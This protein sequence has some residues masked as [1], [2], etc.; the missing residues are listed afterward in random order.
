MSDDK[1][2]VAAAS[3]VH[4]SPLLHWHCWE[5]SVVCHSLTASRVLSQGMT[6]SLEGMVEAGSDTGKELC[7]F[8]LKTFCSSEVKCTGH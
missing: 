7:I 5:M 8:S 1:P 6:S 4:L 3:K 2:T